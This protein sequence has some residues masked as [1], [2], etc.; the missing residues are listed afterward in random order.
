MNTIVLHSQMPAFT[1]LLPPNGWLVDNAG[2]YALWYYN[3]LITAQLAR[4]A[5]TIY[6]EDESWGQYAAQAKA[7]MKSCGMA[8][9]TT[10][11]HMI[12][13]WP[14][15]RMQVLAMGGKQIPEELQFASVAEIK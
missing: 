13:F 3:G 1:D 7:L 8:Y 14:N 10:P 11:D 12:K 5:E 9:S 2:C 6:Y 15:V 4:K